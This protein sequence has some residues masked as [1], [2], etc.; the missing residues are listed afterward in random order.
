[1]DMLLLTDQQELVYINCVRTQDVVWKI[2]QE[3][4]MIGMDKE[5][6]SLK[7]LCCQYDSMMC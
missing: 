2:F 7:N 4:W 5:R 1:M 6:E 3:Q